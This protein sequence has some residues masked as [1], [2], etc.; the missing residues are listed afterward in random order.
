MVRNNLVA[1]TQQTGSSLERA[2]WGP[3]AAATKGNV[4]RSDQRRPLRFHG[5]Y[6][7]EQRH[8]P[9]HK[10]YT[11]SSLSAAR[12]Q[13]RRAAALPRTT[14]EADATHPI[15]PRLSLPLLKRAWEGGFSRQLPILSILNPEEEVLFFVSSSLP[16]PSQHKHAKKM[17][18]VHTME[19]YLTTEKNEVLMHA[20][21]CRNPGNMPRERSQ[22]QSDHVIWDP[23]Y[24]E[25]PEKARL[26]RQTVETSGCLGWGGGCAVRGIEG[27]GHDGLGVHSF[28]SE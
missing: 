21:S 17:W 25:H 2:L 28:F 12:V 5:R 26:Q 16:F 6:C 18:S 20:T 7:G 14:R 11:M 8:R 22:T 1:S 4:P 10:I 24:M 23:F 3:R 13:V 15:S 9:T 19:Y 27:L